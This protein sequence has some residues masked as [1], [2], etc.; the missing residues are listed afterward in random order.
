[1][2]ENGQRQRVVIFIFFKFIIFFYLGKTGGVD[3][4]GSV[5][6]APSGKAKVR[7]FDSQSV[8]MSG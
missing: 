2:K 3:W 1:M 7:L 8:N 5:V 6:G 4:C